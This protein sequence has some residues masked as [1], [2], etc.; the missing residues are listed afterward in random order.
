MHSLHSRKQN[1]QRFSRMKT[2]E[3]PLRLKVELSKGYLNKF[4]VA[5]AESGEEQLV[6]VVGEVIKKIGEGPHLDYCKFIEVVERIADES[7]IKLSAKRLKLLQTVLAE[8]DPNAKPVIKRIHKAN[9]KADPLH[10]FY[11]VEMDNKKCV[12]EYEPDSEL[13]D[14]E[15]VPLLEKGG[16]ESFITREVLPYAQDTWVKEDA[17][18]IGYEI[19][20]NRYFFKPEPLRP[21]QDI[22]SDILALEKETEGLLEE[23][24][25]KK[26]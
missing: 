8:R 15:Q 23:I 22:Q 17:T 10:G 19:N 6:S 20:F 12:V 14:Y 11:E 7:K 26:K 4:R 16:I 13:R 3:R 25:A 9:A 1:N 18:K 24:V 2:V 5:C 21:L